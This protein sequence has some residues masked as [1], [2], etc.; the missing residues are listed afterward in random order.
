[1]FIENFVKQKLLYKN[2]VPRAFAQQEFFSEKP[3]KAPMRLGDLVLKNLKLR[4]AVEKQ[5]PVQI[6]QIFNLRFQISGLKTITTM[7]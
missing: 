1:M 4:R 7:A 3:A 6:M 2:F 5:Y